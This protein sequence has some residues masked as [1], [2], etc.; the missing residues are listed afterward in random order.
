MLRARIHLRTYLATYLMLAFTAHRV[1]FA[2]TL[3][4]IYMQ[5][6]TRGRWNYGVANATSRLCH[7]GGCG[8]HTHTH[9]RAHKSPRIAARAAGGRGSAA[10]Q[11]L[12]HRVSSWPSALAFASADRLH[13]RAHNSSSSTHRLKVAACLASWRPFVPR[14]DAHFRLSR[15]SFCAMFQRAFARDL[16]AASS[17]E[18]F[19]APVFPPA[20]VW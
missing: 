19:L 5:A 17:P 1:A 9:T 14:Q 11:P 18:Q 12:C 16:E 13:A 3:T 20:H 8:A 10:A 7:S 6:R 15:A 2:H 4:H